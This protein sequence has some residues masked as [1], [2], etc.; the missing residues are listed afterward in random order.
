MRIEG[1]LAGV[2][3]ILVL[4]F[5]CHQFIARRRKRN[6]PK[7]VVILHQFPRI[8]VAPNMSPFAIKL[9]TYLRMA[10]IPYK[11]VYTYEFSPKHKTPWIMYNGEVI[12]DTHF[13]IQFLNEKFNVNLNNKLSETQKAVARAMQKMTEEN[14]FWAFI[15]SRWIHCTGDYSL[16][17]I[18]GLNR[19][20]V[21]RVHKLLESQAYSQGVGRHNPKEVESIAR[22]DLQALSIYLGNQKFLMGDEPCETDCAIFGMI[23]LMW[24][25]PMTSFCYRIV[26]E[27]TFPNLTAYFHRMKKEFWPEWTNGS[28]IGEIYGD[29]IQNDV[30][31]A[32]KQN[33]IE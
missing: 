9:E 17:E 13:I 16:R 22:E 7:N 2:F 18:T 33:K 32:K 3:L 30:D 1:F 29:Y 31:D 4:G 19:L 26:K 25:M 27:N 14:L 20:L 5:I 11:N 15:V 24:Q 23:A 28:K 10:N 8:P 12:S 21:W 6:Y